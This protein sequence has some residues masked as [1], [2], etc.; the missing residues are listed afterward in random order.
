M[1]A[2]RYHGAGRLAIDEVREPSPKP[3]EAIVRV[4]SCGICGTDLA[5]RAGNLKRVKPPVTLGHESVGYVEALGVDGDLKTGQIVAVEPLRWCGSCGP[6]QDGNVHLCVQLTLLGVDADGGF[7]PFVSVP[8]EKLHGVP[9]GTPI[10]RIAMAEPCAVSLRATYR[11]G[12]RPHGS[13]AIIGG[14]PIGAL[15]ALIARDVF[16]AKQVFVVEQHRFRADILRGMGFRVLAGVEAVEAIRSETSWGVDVALDCVGTTE[17]LALAMEATKSA[18]TVTLIGLHDPTISFPL[19]GLVLRE[20]RFVGTRIYSSRQF[21]EAV[22]LLAS[23]RIDTSPLIT[24][25]VPLELAVDDAF[26]A[27]A[28]GEDLMKVVVRC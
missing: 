9:P 20:L 5:I 28:R 11:S 12:L 21:S 7:A 25:R 27:L 1:R 26:N 2:L 17:S 13:I 6:C 8:V 19:Q 10:E 23:G 22:A 16:H 15:A 3:G 14:G 18:G 4:V 24:K